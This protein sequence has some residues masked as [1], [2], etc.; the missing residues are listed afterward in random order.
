MN[1]FVYLSWIVGSMLI[2]L[3]YMILILV[4]SFGIITGLL[5]L[6]FIIGYGVVWYY[7][8]KT[9]GDNYFKK[10]GVK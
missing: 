1:K 2:P 3:S 9:V 4:S 10:R 5:N 7:I 6:M 8:Y